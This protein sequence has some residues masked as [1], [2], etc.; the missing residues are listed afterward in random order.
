ME[1]KIKSSY[2]LAMEKM[3]S[4]QPSSELSRDLSDT[5]KVKIAEIRR[6]YKAR[7]AEVEIMHQSELA[8]LHASNLARTDRD[9]WNKIMSLRESDFRTTLAQIEKDEEQAVFEARSVNS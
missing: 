4:N 8:E 5:Q 2:E 6:I 9:E 7:R 1:K 3:K